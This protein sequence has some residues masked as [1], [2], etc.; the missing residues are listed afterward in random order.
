LL[1]I[2][3]AVVNLKVVG[4]ETI[5]RESRQ[6]KKGKKEKERAAPEVLDHELPV[7]KTL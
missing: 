1:D 5:P 4:F 6:E 2:D 3:D 7:L